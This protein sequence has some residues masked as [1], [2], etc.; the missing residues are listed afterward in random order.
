MPAWAGQFRLVRHDFRKSEGLVIMARNRA[1][2]ATLTLPGITRP[3]GR[4][5]KPDAL[6]GAQRQKR[7]RQRQKALAISVTR[8]GN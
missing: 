4:P 8:N 3:V 6:S 7:Y 1:I 2:D 5:R